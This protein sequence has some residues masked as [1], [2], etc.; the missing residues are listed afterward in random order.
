[1]LDVLIDEYEA[2]LKQEN[3]AKMVNTYEGMGE[4]QVIAE[5]VLQG[6]VRSYGVADIS[7]A[8]LKAGASASM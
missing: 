6:L 5:V 8:K 4:S 2:D 3:L 1:M 7:G